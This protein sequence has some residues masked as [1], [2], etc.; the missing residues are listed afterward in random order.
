MRQ[1]VALLLGLVVLSIALACGEQSRIAFASHRDGNFEIFVMNA[2]GSE[3]T[4][5]TENDVLDFYPSWSP[6]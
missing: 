1:A 6:N 3:E 5:L 4:R 2:D